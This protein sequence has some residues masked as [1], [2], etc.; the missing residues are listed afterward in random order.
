MK[1]I[2]LK[3]S[4]NLK[5][6]IN[7]SERIFWMLIILVKQLYNFGENNEK[8]KK[9]FSD[10]KQIAEIIFINILYFRC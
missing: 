2:T 7:N 6:L 3:Q 9:I 5:S 8:T 4:T 1:T 10:L